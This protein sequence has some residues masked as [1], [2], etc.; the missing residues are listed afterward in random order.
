[1]DVGAMHSP[2]VISAL[3]EA[4]VREKFSPGLAAWLEGGRH[5]T[6]DPRQLPDWPTFLDGRLRP[7]AGIRLGQPHAH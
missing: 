2:K 4:K 3:Y 6:D 5:A 1:M 7:K